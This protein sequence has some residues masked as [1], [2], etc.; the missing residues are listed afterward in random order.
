VTCLSTLVELNYIFGVNDNA[1]I[2]TY[3]NNY[4]T[5]FYPYPEVQAKVQEMQSITF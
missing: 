1:K 2:C 5:L 3:K 4:N